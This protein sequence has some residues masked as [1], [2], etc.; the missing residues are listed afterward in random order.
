MEEIK[1]LSIGNSF[2]VDT[3]EHVANIALSLGV[4]SV[5]LGNLYIGGCSIN[6]HF[7]NA[8]NDSSSYIYYTNIGKGWNHTENFKISDAIKNENWDFISIQHG[9][10]DGGFYSDPKSYE[11]LPA[12]I[13]YVK[14]LA[15]EK[16]KIAFNMTWVAEP[17]HTHHEIVS[18][19]GDQML[20]YR[21]I[22]E[23]T[24]NTV[25][26]TEGIDILS[27]VGTAV[28]N[29]RTADLPSLLTRDGYHLSYGLGRYIAGLTFFKA[30]TGCDIEKTEWC[31]DGVNEKEKACALRAALSAL[32]NPF[33]ITEI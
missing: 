12:L 11:K 9:S 30:L 28:Q 22:A 16:T 5:K 32:E 6:M 1:I 7:S 26:A 24:Q 27:P 4:K 33:D 20:T 8:E 21:K 13:K 2:S 10:G 15:G 31:P 3:M 29:A 23:T 18:Y 25:L 14:S 19:G 17:T